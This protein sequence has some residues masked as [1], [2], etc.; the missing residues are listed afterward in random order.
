MQWR[1]EIGRNVKWNTAQSICLPGPVDMYSLFQLFSSVSILYE[2]SYN[3]NAWAHSPHWLVLH[4][5]T[6]AVSRQVS[7]MGQRNPVHPPACWPQKTMFSCVHADATGDYFG[8]C[9][10]FFQG[11]KPGLTDVQAELDRMTRKQDSMVSTNNVPPPTGNEAWRQHLKKQNNKQ[12][13]RPLH[14]YSGIIHVHLSIKHW[15]K[16]PNVIQSSHTVVSPKRVWDAIR[17]Y[18]VLMRRDEDVWKC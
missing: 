18:G 6:V 5:L 4:V 10:L 13:H 12:L 1:N 15:P 7:S 3:D 11:Q 8:L 17:Y 16:F 2:R 9:L 14:S